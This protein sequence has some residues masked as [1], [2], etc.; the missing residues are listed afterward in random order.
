MTQGT[1]SVLIGCHSVVHSVLV[2]IS[3]IKIYKKFPKFW[4][5]VCIFLHDIGHW[6]L[7]YLDNFEEKKIHWRL[8]AQI[9]FKLFGWKGRDFV[10]GHC[11]YSYYSF[12]ESLL[13]RADKYSWYIAPKVWLWLNIFVE[14][15]LRMGYKSRWKAVIKFKGQVKAS[16]DNG[17]YKSTHQMYMDRCERTKCK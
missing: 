17:E 13:Y 16:I 7:N 1:I 10:G 8:G 15:K 5:L 11:K 9:A 6:G 14:P 12:E 2:T 3:W 4:Q